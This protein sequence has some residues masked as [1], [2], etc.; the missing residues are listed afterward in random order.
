VKIGIDATCAKFDPLG[1]F[2]GA[3]GYADLY[4]VNA[5][6]KKK[7]ETVYYRVMTEAENRKPFVP[8]P[9][10]DPYTVVVVSS[11]FDTDQN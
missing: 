1:L 9:A 6:S 8:H 7:R 3:K 2:V 11:R 4:V 5:D 10:D